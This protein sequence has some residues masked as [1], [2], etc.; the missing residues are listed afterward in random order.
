MARTAQSDLFV[1][2]IVAL[3]FAVFSACP[4]VVRSFEPYSAI[5]LTEL[6]A[7]ASVAVLAGVRA[8]V[9]WRGAYRHPLTILTAL[10][11]LPAILLALKCGIG[12]GFRYL[13]R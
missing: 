2:R 10:L 3:A 7:A 13:S 4:L 12:A 9:G 1:A 5:I 11:L 6:C 8:R